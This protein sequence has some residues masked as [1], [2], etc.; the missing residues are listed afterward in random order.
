MHFNFNSQKTVFTQS[1]H[2]VIKNR[3]HKIRKIHE[4][5][6]QFGERETKFEGEQVFDK[7]AHLYKK[8]FSI[9]SL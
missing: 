8:Y 6:F 5:S 1:T 2:R 4:K 7:S 9:Q 3:T